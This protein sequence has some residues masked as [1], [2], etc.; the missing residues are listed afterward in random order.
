MGGDSQETWIARGG[1]TGL[2]DISADRPVL[3]GTRCASCNTTFFPALSLGCEVCGSTQLDA[4]VLE[5]TG[6]LHSVATVHL[7]QGHD[8]EAPFT[9]GEIQLDAGPL[10]RATMAEVVEHD[11]IGARGRGLMGNAASRRRWQRRR[12]APVRV[13][14]DGGDLPR[15]ETCPRRGHRTAP[16][17]AAGRHA[18]HGTR[19]EGGRRHARGRRHRVARASR[20]RTPARPRQRWACRD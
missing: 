4:I 8:I 20:P 19:R 9:I 3:Q 5:A 7:Y 10:I 14:V 2:Y 12:R 13:G 17:P 1:T 6:V 16:L 18:V 11:A 15:A